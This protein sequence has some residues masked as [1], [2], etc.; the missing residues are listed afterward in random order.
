MCLPVRPIF[1]FVAALVLLLLPRPA[2]AWVEASVASDRITVEVDSA[3][4]ATVAHELTMRVRGGPFK[5][6]ELSGIDFDAVPL[7]G[8]TVE[9]AG[10]KSGPLPV[11]VTRGDDDTIRLE[12][13]DEKGL[14]GGTH[15]FKFRYRTDLRQKSR[16]DLRGSWAE[17][18]WVGPRYASGLDV[19]NVTFRVPYAAMAPRLPEFDDSRE[20]ALAGQ[21]S[22]GAMLSTL[23]RAGM[24]DELELVRPHV[25]RGEPVLWRIWTSPSV[26]PFL[27]S[28]PTVDASPVAVTLPASRSAYGKGLVL[29]LAGLLASVLSGLVWVKARAVQFEAERQGLLPRPLVALPAMSRALLSGLSAAAAL[30]LAVRF[31]RPSLAATCLLVSGLLQ[32]HRSAIEPRR[33]RTP[34]R[35]LLISE[36]DAWSSPQKAQRGRFIDASTRQGKITLLVLIACMVAGVAAFFHR[37]PYYALLAAL[38]APCCLPV[39]LTGNFGDLPWAREARHASAL[40]AMAKLLALDPCLKVRVI[41]RFAETSPEPDE[42]RLRVTASRMPEGLSGLEVSV[43]G[44]DSTLGPQLTLIVRA[45]EGSAMHQAFSRRLDFGRGRTK[46]ERVAVKSFALASRRRI[47]QLIG[48]LLSDAQASEIGPS[49]SA[50]DMRSASRGSSTSKPGRKAVPVQATRAA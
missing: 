30:M 7:E 6:T 12:V 46:S 42:M 35:W 20:D 10:G 47:K 39:Y 14:R 15:Q 2:L 48:E 25:A 9:T 23:R 34:G 29:L 43:H 49:A 50:K 1:N 19:A 41:G 24:V 31:E 26:F 17:L 36:S 21:P 40:R 33:L 8:A 32:I 44:G 45:Q 11:T 38:F 28:T 4:Q 3:G 18:A 22:S 16:L 13:L 27:K 37:D 5:G